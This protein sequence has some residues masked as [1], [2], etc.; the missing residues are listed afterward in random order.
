M[1]EPEQGRIS[2]PWCKKGYES[3]APLLFETALQSARDRGLKSLFAAYRRDWEPVLRFFSDTGFANARDMINYWSDPLDLPT[4]VNRSKLPIDRLQRE[5][6]PAVAAM[7]KGI[8]RLP[9]EKLESYLFSNP[10]FPAEAFLV[11]RDR[12]GVPLALGNRAR[13]APPTPT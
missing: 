12:D 1:L 10:Y 6:V 11:L 2:Y 3:A 5:D 4:R 8:V 13:K 9:A 7:G